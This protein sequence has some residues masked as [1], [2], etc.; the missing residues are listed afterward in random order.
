MEKKPIKKSA[1]HKDATW[2]CSCASHAYATRE[3]GRN[4]I[5]GLVLSKRI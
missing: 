1:V 5:A 4:T 3:S 2:T